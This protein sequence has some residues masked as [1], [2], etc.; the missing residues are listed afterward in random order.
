M[1]VVKDVVGGISDFNCLIRLL[2]RISDLNRLIDNLLDLCDGN[3]LMKII[4]IIQTPKSVNLKTK[5][6]NNFSCDPFAERNVYLDYT[7][8]RTIYKV[9]IHI[10]IL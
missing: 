2:G 7:N 9:A 10:T 1:Y 5:C 4:L 3:Y 6:F 8:H